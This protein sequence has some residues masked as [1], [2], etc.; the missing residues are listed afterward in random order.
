MYSATYWGADGREHEI[1]RNTWAD[2][3]KRVDQLRLNPRAFPV[4]VYNATGDMV[5]KYDN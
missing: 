2:L 4:A 1:K 3:L 5:L